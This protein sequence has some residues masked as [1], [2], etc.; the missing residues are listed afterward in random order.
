MKPYVFICAAL[1]AA[2]Q[3]A[4]HVLSTPSWGSDPRGFATPRIVLGIGSCLLFIAYP[5]I[6]LAGTIMLAGLASNIVSASHGS[7][8][9]PFVIGNMAFNP[10]DTMLLA[11][12]IIMVAS[13]PRV[14]RDMRQRGLERGWK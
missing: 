6:R 14:F 3:L 4:K 9:N 1:I 10:A 5:P 12:F 11:G 13:I 7:V 8:P 2:D